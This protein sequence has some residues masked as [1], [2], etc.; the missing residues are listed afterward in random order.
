MQYPALPVLWDF[1][2]ILAKNGI[3]L[4]PDD[5]MTALRALEAVDLGNKAEVQAALEASLI[6][7]RDQLAIF[8]RLFPIFFAGADTQQAPQA[9][10]AEQEPPPEFTEAEQ[11]LL[12][13]NPILQELLDQ[14]AVALQLRLQAAAEAAGLDRIQ[15]FMQLGYFNYQMLSALNVYGMDG[16]IRASAG[17]GGQGGGSPRLEQ[18]LQQLRQRVGD[19]VQRALDGQDIAARE[20]FRRR[21]IQDQSFLTVTPD[22]R[23][24][25]RDEIR[26]LAEILKT[27]AARRRKK[28]KRGKLHAHRTIRANIMHDSV[29]FDRHYRDKMI[30]K[31]QLVLML[32]MS[33]SVR[34]A[35]EFMLLFVYSVQEV[36]AKVR[37]FIFAGNLTE[38]T[39]L[40]KNSTFEEALQEIFTGKPLNIWASSN[41]GRSFEDFEAQYF[42]A[43]TA[44][45][46]VIILG[47]ARTNFLP[48]RADIVAEMA[49]RGREVLWLNP[50][51]RGSWGFGDSAMWDYVPVVDEAVE[52][53]N[54][55]QLNNFVNKLVLG[56]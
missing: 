16:Q 1:W 52:V 41:F 48:P 9:T 19:Y 25:I 47:D 14:D 4:T 32:D 28:Q 5:K 26:R 38:V 21:Q 6:R 3:A 13:N 37:S 29:P 39:D 15:S 22:Q 45:T 27:K 44:K 34:N 54:V 51:A 8:R 43:V 56:R 46:T 55:K 49:R 35:S 53:R 12:R 30:R 7:N 18:A 10:A 24:A 2:E 36:F 20:N 33:E 40:L 42:D 50:E 11:E 17:G 31:P 23:A